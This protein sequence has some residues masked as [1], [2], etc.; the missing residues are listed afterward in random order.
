MKEPN[1]KYPTKQ[2]FQNYLW[3]MVTQDKYQLP[4]AVADT[5]EELSEMVNVPAGR[6]C[7]SASR[8]DRGLTDIP[9][10][11]RVKDCG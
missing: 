4:L 6:I 3:I 8:Y 7:S 2:S 5:A 10:F 9:K 1:R 11:I